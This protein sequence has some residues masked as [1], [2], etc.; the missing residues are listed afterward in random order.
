MARV[1][2]CPTKDGNWKSPY[3]EGDSGT[4]PHLTCTLPVRPS[5]G[6]YQSYQGLSFQ[7]GPDCIA[8]FS[9]AGCTCGTTLGLRMKAASTTFERVYLPINLRKRHMFWNRDYPFGRANIR[10]RDKIDMDQAGFKIEA[11]NPSFGKTVSWLRCD[12]KGQYNHDR[13]VNCMMA[14]ST[15]PHY[16][17]KWHNIWHQEEGGTTIYRVF[18]FFRQSI[19]HCPLPIA[20]CP[21]PIAHCPLPT[22]HCPLP[23]ALPYLPCF[24]FSR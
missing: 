3:G 11:T 5:K 8:I 23:I 1:G 18:I 13:K 24:S 14:M 15:D 10:T 2:V 6:N 12:D 4:S 19:A 17:M 21:L 9:I 22:A 16:N 20:H 7:Y